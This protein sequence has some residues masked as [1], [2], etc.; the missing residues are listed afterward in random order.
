MMRTQARADAVEGGFADGGL[1]P[2][3]RRSGKLRELTGNGDGFGFYRACLC[4]H[5]EITRLD[6]AFGIIDKA[7]DHRAR[8]VR[9]VQAIAREIHRENRQ[10]HAR[11]RFVRAN[12]IVAC[13]ANTRVAR[14]QDENT[15]R[16]RMAVAGG[17]HGQR[18]AV[19]TQQ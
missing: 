9:R 18:S 19:Q 12:F 11:D 8:Q 2:C 14:V 13:G 15:H 16:N 6:C 1:V 4:K 7:L 5:V 10:V 3:V 17:D